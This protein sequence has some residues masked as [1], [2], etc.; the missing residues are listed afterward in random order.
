MPS[1]AKKQLQLPMAGVATA[2]VLLDWYDR[3]R[4]DLPWRVKA[5]GRARRAD[6]YLV[7]LSEIML[8]QTTVAAAIPYYR[9]FVARRPTLAALAAARLEE[10]LA[11]WSGLGYYRRAHRLHATAQIVAERLGGAFPAC[12]EELRALPGI[13]PYT[14]AAVAAIAFGA[15]TTPVDANVE[16]V[17]ARL[18]AVA[19]PLPGARQRIRRLA[20][21]L[22]PVRRAGDFAQALMDLGA[23]ECTPKRPSCLTCPLL[24]VCAAQAQGIQDLLPV[25]AAK[26]ERPLRRGLAFLA[27]REDAHLLLRRRPEAGL[28]GGLWEVPSSAWLASPPPTAEVLREAPVR[29]RWWRVPGHVAHTFTHFRLELSVYRALVPVEAAL[30][31]WSDPL[32][33]RWIDRRDLDRTA[34]PTLMRKVIAHGLSA[35]EDEE[36]TRSPQVA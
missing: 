5:R 26:A 1:V 29:A 33:C 34:L 8:Q 20:R 14:A 35:P 12:E 9:R 28:L 17:V 31:F 32:R 10:V 22:T 25:R 18:F 36:Q 11:A 21:S 24:R 4:R 16:R 19:Q 3:E 6:P 30:T 15:Q 2:Q 7:W 27:L 13:G 23:S